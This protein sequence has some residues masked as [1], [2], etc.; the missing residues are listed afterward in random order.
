RDNPVFTVADGL[1]WLYQHVER[2]SVV[3]KMQVMKLR[4]QASVPG[5]HTFRM[6]E[7]GIQAFPRTLGLSGEA[8]KDR[9]RPR[10]SSGIPELDA[11]LG[12]GIPAGDS[13]LVAGPTGA[14]KSLL[15]THFLDEGLRRG[16]QAIVAVFEERPAEYA[17]RAAGF[18]LDLEAPRHTGKLTTIYIRPL[19]LSVDEMVR[20]ILDAVERTGAKRLVIDSL[21]GFE[22][23]LAPG[24][25]T[26]FRESLYRMIVAVTKVGV[27]IFST[28]EVE[29]TFTGLNFST[30]SISFLCDD[31]IR[32]RYVEIDGQLRKML[33]I[34]KMRGRSQQGFREYE[35]TAKGVV[36]GERPKGYRGP[37]TGVPEPLDPWSGRPRSRTWPKTSRS[38]VWIGALS[39]HGSPDA[40]PAAILPV[41]L[42]AFTP[43]MVAVQGGRTTYASSTPLAAS[44][45]RRRGAD[46]LSPRRSRA[47]S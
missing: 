9:D 11:M 13:L 23:A 47:R 33:V 24:F 41:S 22:L 19:D 26:D 6:S 25:R 20:E 31:L 46:R 36:M 29:E 38:A 40:R 45:A 3:R 18:G 27:T 4:G 43:R 28:V 5:L 35:I 16:E 30:Y 10:L 34:V 12:G 15:A 32:L 37:I 14:G 21:A 44:S 1:F 42:R 17:G 7:A 2:N 39:I 8:K